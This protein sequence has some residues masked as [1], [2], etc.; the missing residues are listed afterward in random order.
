MKITPELLAE[1]EARAKDGTGF[2]FT[3][4]ITFALVAYVREVERERDA[5]REHAKDARLREK[6]A[7]DKRIHDTDALVAKLK[8]AKE[9]LSAVLTACDRGR[10]AVRPGCGVGGMTIEAN[11]KASVINGVSAWEV[12]EARAALSRFTAEPGDEG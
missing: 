10:L 3:P 9:A 11:L 12:E 6:A 8:V 2:V 1:I 5:A 7:E 4:K